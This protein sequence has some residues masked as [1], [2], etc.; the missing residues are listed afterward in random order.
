MVVVSFLF[1]CVV[2]VAAHVFFCFAVEFSEFSD[3]EVVASTS[4]VSS[5]MLELSVYVL[6]LTEKETSF[7]LV[8]DALLQAE[9]IIAA[10]NN[11]ITA[12]FFIFSSPP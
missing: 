5:T 3:L 4:T 1:F 8:T 12:N 10:I 2:V 7:F 11:A 6:L 9:N